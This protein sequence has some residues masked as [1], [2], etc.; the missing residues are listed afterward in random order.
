MKKIIIATATCFLALLLFGQE[1][2]E[3]PEEFNRGVELFQQG[4]YLEAIEQWRKATEKD[5]NLAAAWFN[6]AVAYDITRQDSL[7]IECYHRAAKMRPNDPDPWI[8]LAQLHRRREEPYLAAQA[9]KNACQLQ[10]DDPELLNGL[11]IALDMIGDFAGAIE[12][13][14]KAISLDSIYLSPRVNKIIVHNHAAQYDSAV[15]HGERTVRLFPDEP[16]SWAQLGY[17]YHKLGQDKIALSAVDSSL[18]IFDN[19]AM[20]HYYR[21]LILLSLGNKNEAIEEIG[22]AIQLHEEYRETALKDPE[23]EPLMDM[24]E[25]QEILNR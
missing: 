17:A 6:M 21:G 24:R 19:L 4:K 13:L 23:L 8:Y 11:A 1:A 22:K 18:A 25:F 9:Y 2:K 14:N 7:A 5:E 16:I 20:A 10:K 3:P 15:F 12:A